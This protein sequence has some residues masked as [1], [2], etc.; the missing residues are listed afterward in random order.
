[1]TEANRRLESRYRALLRLY[2][3]SY[4]AGHEE[5][6]LGV[7]MQGAGADQV[8]PT[9][10]E[11]VDLVCAA[12][13]LRVRRWRLMDAAVAR[14]SLAI[15]RPLLVIRVRIAVALWLTA[16]MVWCL[17]HRYWWGLGFLVFIV[18][19]LLLAWRTAE[20]RRPPRGPRSG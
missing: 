7:P 19:H 11:L 20:H 13:R 5:E 4:R 17:A 14:G 2:P 15:R 6:M 3:R 1:M 18:L 9:R 12:L 8:R 10:G 16:L